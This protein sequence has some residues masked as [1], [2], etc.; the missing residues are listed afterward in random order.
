MAFSEVELQRIK[1]IVEPF[2]ARRSPAYALHQVRTEYRGSGRVHC[3]STDGM[4]RPD[5]MDGARC[6]ENPF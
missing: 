5:S 4:G 6:R 2:C 3:R 1:T